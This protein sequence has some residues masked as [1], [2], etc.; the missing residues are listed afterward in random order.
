M[1]YSLDL[2]MKALSAYESG[3]ETQ[4]EIVDTFQISLSTFKRWLQRK[5][6]GMDL[7]PIT[8]GRG[9]PRTLDDSS[10][11]FIEK[12][13]ADNPSITLSELSNKLEKK[14]KLKAGN[15]VLCRALRGLNLRYKKL[16]IQAAEKETASVKK[17]E[18]NT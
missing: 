2:R 10:L 13:V 7:S 17:K 9:R 5:R 12:L 16:S 4:Q 15:A 14:Y 1:S 18:K 8:D 3:T 6:S 11:K